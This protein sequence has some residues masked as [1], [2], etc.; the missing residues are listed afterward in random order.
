MTERDEDPAPGPPR[1]ALMAL[2]L[3]VALVGG[4]MFIM[5]R[6]N[7]AGRM[8]DCFASGRTNCAPIETHNP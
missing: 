1:G 4:F 5:H 6:L 7:E 8:Q 2:L 3:V